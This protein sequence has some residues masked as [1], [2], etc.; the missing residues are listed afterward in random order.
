MKVYSLSRSL[1]RQPQRWLAVLLLIGI[2]WLAGG[3]PTQAA[4]DGALRLSEPA[5][6]PHLADETMI[7]YNKNN[8]EL[9]LIQPDGS[10]DH[11]IWQVPDGSDGLIQS[12]AWRPDGQQIAFVS[13][14]EA[15]CS[16]WFSDI[17]L[18]NPDGTGLRRLTN[19]PAC[20][21]LANYPQ[22]SATVQVENQLANVSQV[23]VYVQGAPTAQVVNVAPGSTVLV[24]FP[25]VADLGDG[26]LQE[27]VVINGG[28]RWFDAAVQGDIVAGH[29]AHLG[30]LTLAKSG[31]D[32]LG[33]T[34]ISWSPDGARLAFQFGTGRLWQIDLDAP[35][36]GQGKALLDPQTNNAIL[37]A[38]PVWSPVGNEVL[39]ERFDT[40]PF[41]ISRTTVDSNDPGK[42][43]AS[44]MLTSGITWLSDGSGLVAADDDS[45]LAHTD[46]YLMKFSDNS[47]TQLTQTS[48]HQAAVYPVVAPDSSRIVYSYFPDAQASP[49][50]PELRMMNLDGSADHLL[51]AGGW[52]ADWSRVAPQMP[53]PTT[54]PTATKTP[55]AQPT[56][57]VTPVPGVTPSVT[58]FPGATPKASLFLPN[59][60]R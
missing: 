15:T 32:A 31:Y 23:L 25:K 37:G 11:L 22:G 7:V 53:T 58:P 55:Q 26:L 46:L 41:T 4:T 43:L 6:A 21:E 19:A 42:A 35:L 48:G 49:S 44:V 52:H 3:Q 10:N 14:H 47:I 30:K 12:V 5:D 18:I 51:A 24:T 59:V 33:P 16:A 20:A 45:L 27:A 36:L 28:V 54:E 17:F 57:S 9:H 50:N 2:G 8:K 60:T 39:Y 29:N 1:W 38:Q 40:R 13:S 56:P 34:Y